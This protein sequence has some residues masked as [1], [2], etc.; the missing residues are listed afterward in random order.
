LVI[1]ERLTIPR[2]EL[3]FS[4]ARSAGPGGQNVNK[5]NTKAVL[6][7]K[8]ADS[9]ALPTVVLERFLAHNAG[10]LTKE[11]ELVIACD[12]HREQGRN[13]GD[14]LQR[15]RALVAAAAARPK[16]RRATKPTRASQ[17][18]RLEAK[19]TQAAKKSSRQS[20]PGEF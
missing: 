4:F 20:P 3:L 1:N 11:G 18:R 12:T 16:V 6:R 8:P 5:L 15:L 9:V 13:V 14:C 10:R 17:Q 7:W 2:S 19:K